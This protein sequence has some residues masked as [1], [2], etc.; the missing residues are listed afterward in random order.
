MCHFVIIGGEYA[1]SLETIL[2]NME[3]VSKYVGGRPLAVF[4]MKP[5]LEDKIKL[6]KKFI[7]NA[8]PLVLSKCENGCIENGKAFFSLKCPMHYNEIARDPIIHLQM[9]LFQ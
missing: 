9:I 5:W 2:E 4:L 8:I 3:M 7:E 6:T 1:G